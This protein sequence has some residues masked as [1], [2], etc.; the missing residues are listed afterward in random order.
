MNSNIQIL[1]KICKKSKTIWAILLSIT[2]GHYELLDIY[3]ILFHDPLE[4]SQRVFLH[5]IIPLKPWSTL[6][7]YIP[8]LRDSP[9]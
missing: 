1:E 9:L 2:V 4:I 3:T 7:I 6:R 8:L 5:D